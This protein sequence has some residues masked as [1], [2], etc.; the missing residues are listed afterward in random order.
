LPV[1]IDAVIDKQSIDSWVRHIYT[2][3]PARF[4]EFLEKSGRILRDEMQQTAPRR[5][6]RLAE[7]IRI[8]QGLDYVRVGPTVPY[9]FFVEYGTRPHE[10]LPRHAQALRFEVEGKTIFARRVWH[11]GFEPRFFMFHALQAAQPRIRE[12]AMS[13]FKTLYGG[14]TP[15]LH[16]SWK[17]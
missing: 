12:L 2:T 15:R 1:E 5:T 4:Q 11:P 16:Q 3:K 14:V 10:I 9:A 17:P 7:S 6:G 8:V 13:V